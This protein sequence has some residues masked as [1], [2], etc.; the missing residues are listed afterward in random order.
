MGNTPSSDKASKM[1]DRE[2]VKEGL[3]KNSMPD[4]EPK[5]PGGKKMSIKPMNFMKKSRGQ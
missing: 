4:R 3:K 1:S 2:S 5:S